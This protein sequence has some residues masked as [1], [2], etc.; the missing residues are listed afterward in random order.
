VQD[1]CFEV[2]DHFL[3]KLVLYLR[4]KRFHSAVVPRLNMMLFLIAHEPEDELKEVVVQFAMGRG[5]KAPEST[6]LS[7]HPVS[8]LFASEG[9]KADG[10][11]LGRAEERQ[12][13]W[14][15]PFL[16]LIHL[17]A[18]HPDYEGE[19][20]GSSEDNVDELKNLAKYLELYFEVF[21]SAEN[22]GYLFYLAATV[23]T[24]QDAKGKE[25]N[26]V[27]PLSSP[28]LPLPRLPSFSAD[29]GCA[30]QTLYLL[31]ELSQHLLKLIAK[32]HGWPIS[33]YPGKVSIPS[34]LYKK[35]G[36]TEEQMKVQQRTFVSEEV[37]GKLEVG[38]EKK[39]VRLSFPL[40][41]LPFFFSV[42]S[43]G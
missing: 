1:P 26:S 16:R 28:F 41:S 9:D 20:V 19:L 11:S 21:A 32:R 15:T 43:A 4:E 3:R 35:F 24:V 40:L 31:S 12:H 14:E 37:L 30:K 42:E 25:Y 6:S 36:S 18:H 5:R 39:K 38:G 33:T 10:D 27:R 8:A 29:V 23:K 34:D 22:V 17:L 7:F 13:F 2:R